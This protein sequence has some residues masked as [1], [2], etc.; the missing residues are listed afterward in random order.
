MSQ[1]KDSLF[2]NHVFDYCVGL[3]GATSVSG[4]LPPASRWFDFWTKA[5]VAA[6]GYQVRFPLTNM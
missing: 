4:Y 1:S 6:T 5:P 2:D 3:P